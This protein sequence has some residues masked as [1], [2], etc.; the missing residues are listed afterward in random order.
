MALG[1]IT[2]IRVKPT[3]TGVRVT[4]VRKSDIGNIIVSMPGTDVKTT[5]AAI[6]MRQENRER[7]IKLFRQ[8]YYPQMVTWSPIEEPKG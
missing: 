1:H 4:V 3:E 6:E 8:K 2:E 5:L 7:E